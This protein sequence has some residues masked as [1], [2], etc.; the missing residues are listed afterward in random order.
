MN[1]LSLRDFVLKIASKHTLAR[2]LERDDFKK[3]FKENQ[4]IALHELFYP[5]LQA[6]DSVELKADVEIGGTDQLF[7][8][9]LGRQ[10]QE[11]FG[12]SPSNYFNSPLTRRTWCQSGFTKK[13]VSKNPNCNQK[14]IQKN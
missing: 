14:N 4:P 1:Q 9:L 7:N 10:L 6:Y 2:Q 8:L 3:R 11:T 5:L 13:R 12:Q